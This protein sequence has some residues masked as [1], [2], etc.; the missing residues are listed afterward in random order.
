[1]IVLADLPRETIFHILECIMEEPFSKPAA[2]AVLNFAASCRKFYHIVSGFAL[3]AVDQD[4]EHLKSLRPSGHLPTILSLF[5]RRLAALCS[6]CPNRARHWKNG[7][8]FNGLLV[9]QG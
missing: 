8:I 5:C 4:L 6:F 9:C 3:L 7:E 1:M 2:L